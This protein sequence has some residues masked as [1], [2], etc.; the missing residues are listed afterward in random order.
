MAAHFQT[1]ALMVDYAAEQTAEE[2]SAKEEEKENEVGEEVATDQSATKVVMGVG[3]KG[4][5]KNEELA[6]LK[7]AGIEP[8]IAQPH[9][10]AVPRDVEQAEAFE[11]N[12][13]NRKSEA[14]KQAMRDR[15]EKVERS[16]RH[17][18][19]HGGARR[20]TLCGHCNISKRML[21]SG[22][23][24]NLSILF[25]NV[26]GVGTPKQ[27]IASNRKKTGAAEAIF[28]VYAVLKRALITLGG[29]WNPIVIIF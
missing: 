20:T 18:L 1:A 23:S 5:H 24:F 29:I 16:F 2:Q 12:R 4:Y 25:W 14:G 26:H 17:V 19:D 9:G 15:A 28:R 27:L 7:E 13:A 11:A 21:L 10:K 6:K 8:V 22:L 3:D